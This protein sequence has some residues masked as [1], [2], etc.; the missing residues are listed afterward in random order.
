[1]FGHY[2]YDKAEI[3]RSIWLS[4]GKAVILYLIRKQKAI[5]FTQYGKKKETK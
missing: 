4:T 5:Y 2:A 1:M 3:R